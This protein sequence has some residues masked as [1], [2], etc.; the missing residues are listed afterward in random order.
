MYDLH[1]DGFLNNMLL[2][3]FEYLKKI[4]LMSVFLCLASLLQNV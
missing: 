3:R 2:H 1:F 4:E